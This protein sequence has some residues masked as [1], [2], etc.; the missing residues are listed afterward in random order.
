MLTDADGCCMQQAS[1]VV[2]L[3][4]MP[5]LER[6]QAA[7]AANDRFL[8]PYALFQ[9]ALCL[10]PY[11]L[12]LMPELERLQAALAANDR[13]ADVCWRMLTYADVC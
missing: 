9:A 12:C 8:L 2:C 11:A 6:L 1:S 3:V 13:C 4:G 7:L 10:M 5:V